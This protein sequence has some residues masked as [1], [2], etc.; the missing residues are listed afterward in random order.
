M[1]GAD[2]RDREIEA[3]RERLATVREASLRMH[4]S[5]DFDAVLQGV[6]DSAQALTG[7]R[8]G[9]LTLND[10]AGAVRDFLSAGFTEEESRRL[11]RTEDGPRLFEYLS[12][13]EHPLRLRDYHGYMQSLGMPAFHPPMA[14]SASLSFL[15]APIRHRGKAVANFFLAEKEDGREFTGEDEQTLVMFASQA[16][17][18]IASTRR[19]RDEQKARADLEALIETSPVGVVVFDAKTGALTSVNRESLRIVDDLLEPG[20]GPAEALREVTV[21]REDG[22]EFALAGMS[23]AEALSAG[24]TVRGEEILLQAPSG[25]RV[26][27]L[28]NAT[29][30]GDGDG[31][32]ETYVVTLQ[33]LSPQRELERMRTEFLAMVSHELRAPLTSVKG[34]ITTL[35]DPP[36]ALSASEMRQFH[37]IVNAQVDRMQ[38]LITDLLDVARIETGTLAV[39]PEPTDAAFLL[40]EARKAFIEGGGRHTITLAIADGLPWVLAD[41][42]RIA[43]TLGNLL[44][45]AAQHSPESE[46]IEMT[47][48][49]EGV[50][51]KVSV[52]DKGRGIPGDSL[53]G[54][55]RKYSRLDAGEQGEATGLGLAI[56][57]G[58]VEAHGGRIQAESGG[59]GRGARFTFSI[60]AAEEGS[61]AMPTPAIP[62]RPTRRS[63][64]RLARVLA[65]DADP[66]ALR[67]VR[68]ALTRAGCEAIVTGDPREVLRLVAEEKPDLALLDLLL[69]DIDGIDLMKAITDVADIPVIFLSAFG[70]DQ[71]VARAF[72]LGAAD[73]VVK[74]FSPVELGARIRAAL[75]RRETPE[76]VRP[77]VTGDLSVNFT[78]RLVTVG[79]RKVDLTAIE[80]AML[81]ELAAHGGTVLKY[82]H[83]LRRV[84]KMEGDADIRPIRTAL[85]SL[86]RKLG[87]AADNP[88]Y[89]HTETRVGYRMPRPETPQAGGDGA[90]QG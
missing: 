61:Y 55:F 26:T 79:G 73:Y 87:D 66:Q 15:S 78:E 51:V 5:L 72:D 32:V 49:A 64:R 76:P 62:Q 50:Y 88:R 4:D 40:N 81:A 75:R 30:I 54:L 23:M 31:D 77:Y 16:S 11:W 86:R 38:G 6:L 35:L 28:M 13:L 68:E 41:R 48:G 27:A 58:I 19:Y 9:V 65:V 12:K 90:E 82:E 24:E 17:A 60:P 59:P 84:W 42:R 20:S 85:S 36:G 39:S 22:R 34:A 14:V 89:I 44:A 70:Q 74:P 71:L 25:R 53:P 37:A 67:Y 2:A 29:P 83:L 18:I 46:P 10:E 45:N 63:A 8:Y 47:A 7:A 69:P 33:D 3:L 56:S 57:K 80:Y 52:S 43:Q 21:R 1:S